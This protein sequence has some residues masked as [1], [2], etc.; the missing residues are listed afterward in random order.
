MQECEPNKGLSLSR[1]SYFVI[2]DLLGILLKSWLTLDQINVSGLG[3]QLP[4]M[5]MLSEHWQSVC[6]LSWPQIDCSLLLPTTEYMLLGWIKAL[7]DPA[8]KRS[9]L[10]WL[11]RD[12]LSH[13]APMFPN[14]P[15]LYFLV[16]HWFCY[17]RIQG[18]MAKEMRGLDDSKK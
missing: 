4:K 5:F 11:R 16:F 2:S 8:S 18:V 13:P 17:W 6:L 10:K 7:H 1:L 14:I 3:L 15:L 9:T 12:L